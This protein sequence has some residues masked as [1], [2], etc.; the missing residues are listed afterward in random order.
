MYSLHNTLVKE[1]GRN[2]RWHEIDG[3]G[4]TLSHLW[5]TFETVYLILNHPALS[6]PVSLDLTEYRLTV[7]TAYY[8]KTVGEWLTLLGNESL[9]TTPEIPVIAPRFVKYSDAIQAGYNIRPVDRTAHTDSGLPLSELE[10]LLLTKDGLDYT[11]FD[12]FGLVTVN[13]LIHLTDAGPN[14]VHVVDGHISKRVA[15]DTLVGVLNFQ[16][17]GTIKR[18]PITREM[19]A[20]PQENLFLKDYADLYLDMDLTG[21]TVFVVI[22]GY[23]HGHDRL[24][25]QIG[26][27]IFR[28]DFGNF[29]LVDRFYESR[30]LIDL[31]SLT[32][33]MT[34]KNGNFDQLDLEEVYSDE[35]LTRY[36]TL[37][38][39]FFLVIESPNVF[40][41]RQELEKL[42]SPGRYVSPVKPEWPV[43]YGVGRLL[44]YHWTSEYGQFLIAGQEAQKPVYNY[45]TT[46]WFKN[47]SL[48]DT[49]STTTP[50]RIPRAHFLKIGR[51]L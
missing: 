18:V 14:G 21:K 25:K 33:L 26:D 39:S 15:N 50:F 37:S 11:H 2:G 19:V 41:D 13:G 47:V 44:D 42:P 35:W 49:R 1:R 3:S 46:H 12:Q 5:N 8:N 10:D 51:D 24:V 27:N 30:G 40:I 23:L 31:S 28:V 16:D 45:K 22:G 9:P 4:L 6:H 29:P 36:L 48:D 20:T 43:S 17:V 38:Q 7:N 34:E 32:E